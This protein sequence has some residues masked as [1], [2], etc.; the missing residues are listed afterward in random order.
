MKEAGID[1]KTVMEIGGWKTRSM[2]DRYSHPSMEHKRNA[3]GKIQT[4]KNEH[5]Q[6]K[7]PQKTTPNLKLSL[8]ETPLA[9]KYSMGE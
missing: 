7:V 8:T 5:F 6:E 2:V 1:D 9:D 3:I 4:R